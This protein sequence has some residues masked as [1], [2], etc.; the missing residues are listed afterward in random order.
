MDNLRRE[1]QELQNTN[2]VNRKTISQRGNENAEQQIQ[3]LRSDLSKTVIDWK[4]AER[5]R[6]IKEDTSKRLQ[7]ELMKERDK[8]QLLLSQVSKLEE[9]LLTANRELATFRG[10]DVYHAAKEAEL[11]TYRS[12]KLMSQSHTAPDASRR[13]TESPK[14]ARPTAQ[15]NDNN[16]AARGAIENV[17][18]NKPKHGELHLD[19]QYSR[20]GSI[21]EG[22]VITDHVPSITPPN[23]RS[24]S[25]IGEPLN[26]D[27]ISAS[28]SS[29][30]R[31]D[32]SG[33]G[34]HRLGKIPN[35][36]MYVQLL[37]YRLYLPQHCSLR[38]HT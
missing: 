31:K 21:T 24:D 25:F 32:V 35:T 33:S 14:F 4:E 36:L 6:Q 27:D 13:V 22:A 18:S 28:A 5:E 10:L 15:H 26:I 38:D 37:T 9:R 12:T 20:Q 3:M 23:I 30:S 11:A 16:D 1:I 17:Q 34:A 7:T 8:S 29:I 19:R 2:D